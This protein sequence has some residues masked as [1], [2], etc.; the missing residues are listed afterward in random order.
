MPV[1]LCHNIAESPSKQAHIQANYNTREQV[2]SC[3]DRLTFDGIYTNVRE[4][5]DILK[6][7]EVLLFVVGNTIGGDNAFDVGKSISGKEIWKSGCFWAQN[8]TY[9][10]GQMFSCKSTTG[11]TVGGF[12]FILFLEFQKESNGE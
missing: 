1:R 7:R 6:G 4:N 11:R 8:G 3:G 10:S 12:N 9:I 5:R 2:A